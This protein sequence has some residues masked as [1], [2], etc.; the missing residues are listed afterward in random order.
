MPSLS[1]LAAIKV[2]G[3]PTT[4]EPTAAP[5]S[6]HAPLAQPDGIDRPPARLARLASRSIDSRLDLLIDLGQ[7]G[8]HDRIAVLGAELAVHLGR[9]TE[10]VGGQR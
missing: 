6:G 7:E 9:G 4:T 1:A 8:L 10:V 2:R 5:A 3:R